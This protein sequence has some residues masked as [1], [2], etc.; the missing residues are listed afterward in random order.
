MLVFRENIMYIMKNDFNCFSKYEIRDSFGIRGTRME[1]FNKFYAGKTNVEFKNKYK[2]HVS[3]IKC[4]K[5]EKTEFRL[6]QISFYLKI[7]KNWY[8]AI[9]LLL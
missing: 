3:E 7:F 6:S 8:L 2:K 9:F 1:Y 4:K 5:K